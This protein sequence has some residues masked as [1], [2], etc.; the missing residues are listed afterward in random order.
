[1]L[2]FAQVKMIS[3]LAEMCLMKRKH[4]ASIPNIKANFCSPRIGRHEQKELGRSS[5]TCFPTKNSFR[6]IVPEK[7]SVLAKAT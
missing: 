1:M 4:A 3:A 5:K 2:E 7:V 6:M